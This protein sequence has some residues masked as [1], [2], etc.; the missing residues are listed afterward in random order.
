MLKERVLGEKAELTRKMNSSFSQLLLK[1]I[2]RPSGRNRL[3]MRN[4][5][6]GPSS[7]TD[8]L[9][10]LSQ[11][12]NLS[13]ISNKCHRNYNICPSWFSRLLWGMNESTLKAY[14]KPK[15][16][17]ICKA[18][19]T[20]SVPNDISSFPSNTK[21]QRRSCLISKWC[22]PVCSILGTWHFHSDATLC[23][24]LQMLV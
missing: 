23:G 21:I 1:S 9:C 10:S 12:T 19:G 17:K 8:W 5:G 16:D 3:R 20:K 13:K 24:I 18:P 6:S 14:C 4:L 7:T 11:L 2:R 22:L 15:R